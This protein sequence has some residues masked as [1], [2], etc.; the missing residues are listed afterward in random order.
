M[1]NLEDACDNLEAAV[2]QV[3]KALTEQKG[4][5]IDDHQDGNHSN[6]NEDGEVDFEDFDNL[7]KKKI[8]IQKMLTGE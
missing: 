5:K 4:V 2:S 8:A 1:K 3:R 7:S 6:A